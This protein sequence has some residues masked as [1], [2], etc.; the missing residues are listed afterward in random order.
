MPQL[1]LNLRK[2]SLLYVCCD[3]HALAVPRSRW[4][5][6]PEMWPN[7]RSLK[8]SKKFFT[9]QVAPMVYDRGKG[10]IVKEGD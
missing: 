5:T 2:Y 9:V 4:N 10:M 3:E 6:D 1:S 8:T 7:D